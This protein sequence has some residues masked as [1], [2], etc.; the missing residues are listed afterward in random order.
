MK[1][2]IRGDSIR[3]RL[4]QP[5]VENLA[6]EGRVVDA[7]NFGANH[8]L[9]YAAVVDADA[10][11][12]SASLSDSVVSVVLPQSI[13]DTW[14][15]PTEVSIHGTQTLPGDATLSILVE[16]D[17]ACLVP[18]EGEDQENLFPNPGTDKC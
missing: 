14:M 16:K 13:V 11:Q 1:L 10:D 12:V 18:R 9:E 8:R 6:T 17:F 7:I 2:R 5:E 15:D 4:S 3:L